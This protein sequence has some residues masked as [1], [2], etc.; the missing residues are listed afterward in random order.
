MLALA[1]PMVSAAP[2]LGKGQ[3]FP[4][5]M[6]DGTRIDIE[7][8]PVALPADAPVYVIH[9]WD[10]VNWKTRPKEEQRE[11]LEDYTFELHIEGVQVKLRKWRHYYADQDLMKTGFLV[12]FNANHFDAGEYT[13]R[14][15]WR[16]TDDESS[17][18]VTFYAP[19]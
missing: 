2:K 17:I 7:N 1:S 18:T 12:E 8:G 13:F 3:T 14:G 10:L 6:L 11:F 5:P 4:P 15:V 9:G 19:Q 16:P